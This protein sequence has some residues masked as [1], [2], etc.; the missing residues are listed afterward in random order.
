MLDTFL[1]NHHDAMVSVLGNLDA[2]MLLQLQRVSK[3]F[4]SII[5]TNGV[6]RTGVLNT[7]HGITN[8]PE[9][10]DFEVYA[11][12]LKFHSMSE[13]CSACWR[14]TLPRA[15]EHSKFLLACFGDKG[16]RLLNSDEFD[17]IIATFYER[18][19]C[20]FSTLKGRIVIMKYTK[21]WKA[22]LYSSILFQSTPILFQSTEAII[23]RISAIALSKFCFLSSGNG[24]FFPHGVIHTDGNLLFEV[25]RHQNATAAYYNPDHVNHDVMRLNYV[26]DLMSQDE[27]QDQEEDDEVDDDD[28]DQDEEVDDD[29][30]DQDEEVD[31][32]EDQEVDEEV[33]D[34]EENDEDQEVDEEDEEIFK[35]VI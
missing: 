28:E 1:E 21:E 3:T 31:D 16:E 32:D 29:D 24:R 19:I 15:V 5:Q 12:I 30:E 17:T 22:E 11:H 13:K 10:T 14:V 6:L 34:E 8:V 23:D 35:E 25:W 9:V 20:A 18:T 4:K 7:F 33:D 26:S 27:D 2:K